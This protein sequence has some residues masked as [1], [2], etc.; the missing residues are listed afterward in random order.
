MPTQT[1]HFPQTTPPENVSQADRD[2]FTYQLLLH[3]T[4]QTRADLCRSLGWTD[5][6]VRDIA[7]SFG[8]E[9]VRCQAGF[10]LCAQITRD[11]LNLVKQAIDAFHSQ[12]TKMEAYAHGLRRRL[13][14]L[15]G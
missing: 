6:K 14:A 15:I 9:I 10:K 7:E 2:A 1:D 11:D 13:H 12:A 5:R 3:D 8:P 4:W